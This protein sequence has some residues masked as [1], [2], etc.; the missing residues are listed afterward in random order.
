[1]RAVLRNGCMCK[2]PALCATANSRALRSYQDWDRS[3]F[4]SQI[5]VQSKIPDLEMQLSPPVLNMTLGQ[6]QMTTLARA[7]DRLLMDRTAWRPLLRLR[8]P[9]AWTGAQARARPAREQPVLQN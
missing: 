5:L 4:N 2:K 9:G 7:V 1:M 6:T 8:G 3:Q